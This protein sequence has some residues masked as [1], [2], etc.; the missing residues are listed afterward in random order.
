MSKRI[1][2][3]AFAGLCAALL[4]GPLSAED[5]HG[6][7]N[8]KEH[9]RGRFDRMKKEL[10]LTDEQDKKLKE[11]R[12][13]HRKKAEALHEERRMKKEALRGE[14][15][16]SEMDKGK[17]QSIHGELKSIDGKL[18]DHRLEGI[19]AVSEILTP[20]QRKKFH[21]KM[22][23]K[24]GKKRGHDKEGREKKRERPKDAD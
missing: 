19:L 23:A 24:K 15:E 9:W 7:R 17:I 13:T 16:K 2:S 8:N 11:H 6:G 10:N 4:S 5:G 20:E 3:I 14:L 22:R 1:V 12:K 18:A 21:E